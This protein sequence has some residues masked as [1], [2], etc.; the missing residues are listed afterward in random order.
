LRRSAFQ[1]ATAHLGKAIAMADRAGATAQRAT[2]GSAVPNQRLTQ[3]QAAY[4]NALIAAR[5]NP[6]RLPE[7]R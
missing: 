2:G 3:L 1:E 4:G 5:G 6:A 7:R